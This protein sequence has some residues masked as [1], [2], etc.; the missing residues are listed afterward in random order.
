[1]R[2]T[3]TIDNDVAVQI[4]ELRR[5]RGASL[6]AVVNDALR[7]GLDEI[8]GAGKPSRKAFRTRSFDLGAAKIPG[9]DDVAEALALAEG[10]DHR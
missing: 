10:E 1:M 9:L 3:L 8:R 4:D 2:T 5:T 6:K 7:R